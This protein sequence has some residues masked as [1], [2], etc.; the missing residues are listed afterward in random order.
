M[1]FDL[2]RKFCRIGDAVS[3]TD[4]TVI[5]GYASLFGAC[6]QGGD[7]VA[8]GAYGASLAG[9]SA[10][11]GKVKMLWQHDPAQPIGVWD[12]VRE[13]ARGLYV[14]G[15][16]LPDVDKGREAIALI[17]AG[18]IDGLSIG[19]RTKKASKDSAG[20]RHL[21]ELELWEVSLVTFPMLPEA[22]VGAK[23][24]AP[25]ADTLRSLAAALED[26]RGLLLRG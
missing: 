21:H 5:E 18:A 16:I 2:E 25:G 14:K 15:R 22:R 12:E 24:D 13:D 17:G 11:G 26:A 3:V 4:G 19:Y 23:G 6:D 9:L 8:P 20:K 7:V 10:K 1:G